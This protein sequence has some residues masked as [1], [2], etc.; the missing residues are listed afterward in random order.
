[1]LE[2]TKRKLIEA[3][4]GRL[5]Y[6]KCNVILCGPNDYTL[7]KSGPWQLNITCNVRIRF[8]MHYLLIQFQSM[9]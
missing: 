9:F 5:K 8:H 2:K 7:T 3:L 4:N 1:M 6:F